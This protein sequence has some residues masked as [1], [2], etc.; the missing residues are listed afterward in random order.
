MKRLTLPALLLLFI[1]FSSCGGKPTE[2]KTKDDP[3]TCT[4]YA[5][6][7]HPDKTSTTPGKC[8]ECGMEMQPV[9][10]S[11]DSSAAGK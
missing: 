9:K 8:P 5:C 10:K 2:N 11:A 1:T 4:Q 3:N 6:P 7:M